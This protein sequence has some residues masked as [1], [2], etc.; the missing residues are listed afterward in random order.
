MWWLVVIYIRSYELVVDGRK[1]E[2]QETMVKINRCQKKV[3][4]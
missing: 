2:L 3:H 4:S 1:F